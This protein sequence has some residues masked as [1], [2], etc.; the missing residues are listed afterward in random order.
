MRTHS[1][2]HSLL[3]LVVTLALC[4]QKANAQTSAPIGGF[5]PYIGL[6]LSNE[7]EGSAG[8][9]STFFLAQPS[10]TP[11][12]T[13]LGA[14]GS[15][16]FD[17]ALLDSGAATHILTPATDAGFDVGGNGF[18]GT[19]T[20]IIGG[21]TGTILLDINDPLGFYVAGTG[22]RTAEGATI[23]FNNSSLQGQTSVATLSAPAGSDWTLPNIVGLPIAAQH[24][25]AIRNDLPQIFQFQGR[26]V[27]TP[28]ITLQ[29]LG[30][31]GAGH[32]PGGSD[33]IRHTTFNLSP[34]TAFIQG[35]LYVFNIQNALNGLPL[36][37]NPSSPTVLENGALQLTVDFD[38]GSE[39]L[40][41]EFLFDT[42]ADLTVISEQTAVLL[43]I[44]PTLD[45]P[46]FNLEVVGSGGVQE[47]IPGFFIDELNLNTAGGSF[48]VHN[49]PVAVLDVANPSNPGNIVPGIIGTHLFHDR[50]IVIDAN[51]ATGQGGLGPNLYISD[52]VTT[53]H[54]WSNSSAS[55]NWQTGG[56][57]NAAGTPG[58]LW[59]ATLHNTSSIH[60]QA[61]VTT[62]SQVY[63]IELSGQANSKMTLVVQSGATL[64]SY[65]HIHV[66]EFAVVDLQ[67][68][69]IN[70][71]SIQLDNGR[72]QGNGEVFVGSGPLTGQIR[73]LSGTVAPGDGIGTLTL[74]G[75]FSNR[76]NG[77]LEIEIGGTTA[78]TEFD[79]FIIDGTAFIGGEL[80]VQLFDL[81][82]GTFQPQAGDL[83]E[84]LTTTNG[85]SGTF[86]T[87][88][89][90]AGTDWNVLY[91]ANAIVL[92]FAAFTSLPGDFDADGDVDADDFTAWQ[93]GYSTQS[94]ALVAN[95]DA[96][97][98][99][100]VDG[101]D[102]L[103]WQSNYAPN[104]GSASLASA[105]P[106]PT[107][108]GLLVLSL[109]MIALR[110]SWA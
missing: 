23:A 43:G 29:A 38:H 110:K 10:N 80:D 54:A 17:I 51:P 83:F 27:R 28:D 103:A 14:G 68:G 79:Q 65:S 60:K 40:Q 101:D 89:L 95:G 9:G 102:F 64:T 76:P 11:G 39:S 2:T 4:A 55:G 18:E 90:P 7:F 5:L 104:S 62:D 24:S 42:G 108:L 19:E 86:D 97:N 21:A 22:S 107:T 47:G 70:A 91:Q 25:I 61:V 94:G 58:A 56:N 84:I 52:P 63:Q 30:T 78:G 15:P 50:N 53:V 96:D 82:S 59:D 49:V 73:N 16:Y 66:A 106:E 105:V 13:M 77:T 75:D 100:D 3:V 74:D 69:K 88:S 93:N 36:H 12:G 67:G 35:P 48:I 8:G 99:G 45:T 20:Q 109:V 72:L 34:G 6:G 31:G 1:I 32:G 98:D 41:R 37:D 46:D 26:T 85:V 71:L 57:W 87:L 33:I 44:D 81:G 92:E